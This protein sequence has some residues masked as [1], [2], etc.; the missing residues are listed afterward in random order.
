M[1]RNIVGTTKVDTKEELL[2]YDIVLSTYAVVESSW[3]RQQ[4][5]FTRKGKKVYDKSL[6]HA[7]EW[8]RVVLDEGKF[9]FDFMT[10]H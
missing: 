4:S 9:N 5:G 10:W 6:I 7:V 2:S 1:Q 3:R 8:S